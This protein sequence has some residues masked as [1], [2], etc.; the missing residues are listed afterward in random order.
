MADKRPETPSDVRRQLRQEAG[1][2]CCVCGHPFIQFHHIIPWAVEQHF[3]PEDMM[4]ACGSCHPL[5]T[6]GAITES[7]QRQYKSRPKNILDKELRGKLYVTT[8]ELRIRLGGAISLETP[9]LITLGGK[10]VLEVRRN[11]EDGRMLVSAEIQS[12][13]GGVIGQLID[14]EWSM[15]PEGVWDFECFP[16]NATIRQGLGDISFQVDARDDPTELRGKWYHNG[17]EIDFGPEYCKI[18]GG[19]RLIMGGAYNQYLLTIP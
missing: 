13:D 6:V 8:S 2:G 4:A 12:R 7:E 17:R 10:T 3:R 11:P 16:R 15:A 9:K 1:F 18:E 5:F 19:P 14:N